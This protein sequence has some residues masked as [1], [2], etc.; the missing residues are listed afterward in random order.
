MCATQ[1]VGDDDATSCEVDEKPALQLAA[2][3]RSVKARSTKPN[4][5]VVIGHM[6][7]GTWHFQFTTRASLCIT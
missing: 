3:G 7:V 1:K 2:P 5:A 4:G 6:E